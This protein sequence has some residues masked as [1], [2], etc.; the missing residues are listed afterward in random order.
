MKKMKKLTITLRGTEIE[1]GS[2]ELKFYLNETQKK[3]IR[4]STIEK[5]FN[6]LMDK[7]NGFS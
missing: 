6:N 7:F 4:K 5:Y 2:S 3:H 1:L